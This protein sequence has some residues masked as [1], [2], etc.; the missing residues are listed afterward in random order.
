MGKAAELLEKTVFEIQQ[1]AL[2]KGIEIGATISQYETSK[3]HAGL[4]KKKD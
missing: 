1:K 3:K 2:E 4:L